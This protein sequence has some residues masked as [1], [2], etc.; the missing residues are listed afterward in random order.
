MVIL[1]MPFYI[2]T[3]AALYTV[4]RRRWVAITATYTM[5]MLAL[6]FS[7]QL[8]GDVDKFVDSWQRGDWVGY[9]TAN[10]AEPSTLFLLVLTVLAAHQTHLLWRP[11]QDEEP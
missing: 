11:P 1:L 6:L 8:L 5:L 2:G 7:Y 3:M 4:N 9:L 10:L